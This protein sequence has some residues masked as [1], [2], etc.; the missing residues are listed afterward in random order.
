VPMRYGRV[1]LFVCA[2]AM[3]GGCRF[4]GGES[5]VSSTQPQPRPDGRYGTWSGDPFTSAGIADASGG[6]RTEVNYGQGADPTAPGQLNPAFDQPAKGTGLR[7][8]EQVRA[9]APGFGNT[10]APANQPLP[11]TAGV[12]QQR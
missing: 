3:L 11:G 4:E 12:H 5:F 6:T 2:I 8:G 7:P 10:N 1:L 9:S